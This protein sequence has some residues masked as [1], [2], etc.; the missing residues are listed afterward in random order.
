M[1]LQ[2]D[3]QITEAVPNKA[4]IGKQ[5]KKDAKEIYEKLANLSLNDLSTL[6]NTIK[7]GG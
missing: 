6:D 1:L 5:F 2:I 7:S 4:H 3:I